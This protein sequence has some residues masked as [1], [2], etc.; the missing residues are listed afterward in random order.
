MKNC[1][2]ITLILLIIQGCSGNMPRNWTPVEQNDKVVW[3]ND[4]SEVAVVVLGF[5]EKRSGLLSKTR[6]Q[7]HFKHRIQTQKIKG[8]EEPRLITEWRDYKNGQ[9]FYMKQAGYFIVESLLENGKRRFDKI[10]LNGNEILIVETPDNEHQPCKKGTLPKQV[11]QTVIPSPDGQQLA[12][13]YSPECGK[14]TVEFLHANNLNLFDNQ[15]IDIDEPMNAKWYSNGY[16]ILTS[17]S[18]KKA[19]KFTPLLPPPTSTTPQR[20]IS[21]MTTSSDVSL[22]GKKVYFEGK[23]L[24]VKKV[25]RQKQFGC[26]KGISNKTGSNVK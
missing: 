21:P 13:I 10:V 14:V 3:A 23:K 1:L 15:T 9:I 8:S 6:S 7:R 11:Y 4:G 25:D 22:D 16:V 19:W 2:L 24:G 26:P 18:H 12:H 20:C 17:K 5:E